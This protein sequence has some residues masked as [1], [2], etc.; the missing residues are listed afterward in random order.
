[1]VGE[2]RARNETT[3]DRVVE[4]TRERGELALVRAWWKGPRTTGE[5]TGLSPPRSSTIGVGHRAWVPTKPIRAFC[6]K[7]LFLQREARRRCSSLAANRYRTRRG[8]F[9]E[10]RASASFHLP[11]WVDESDAITISSA[12]RNAYL[13][14]SF[15][16]LFSRARM[17]DFTTSS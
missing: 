16:G 11:W 14:F 9:Y 4:R 8:K 17:I 6:Q 12:L 15:L 10:E 1:M 5:R 7:I 2:E 3:I 13:P